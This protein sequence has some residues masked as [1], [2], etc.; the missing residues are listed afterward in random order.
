MDLRLM[1]TSFRFA[2]RQGLPWVRRRTP[3]GS[4]PRPFWH[5]LAADQR[6][7]SMLEF[8]MVGPML[9]LL[10]MVIVDLGIMLTTQSMLDGAARDAA[11]LIRT[12]Q[13]AASSNPLSTFQTL[14]CSDMSP[15]MSTST[16]QSQVLFEVNC[17][18]SGTVSGCLTTNLGFG[19][20][21]FSG[22]T[23]NQGQAGAAGSGT[24]CNFNPGSSTTIVG[25]RVTYN[26]KFIVPWVGRC[27]TGGACWFGMGTSGASGTGGGNAVPLV[28][29]VVFQ[30]EP[31]P[32]S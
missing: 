17:Y 25:V 9:V 23:Y 7:T 6:G 22:C 13:V 15:V 1:L 32:A 19:A 29:T 28:S 18:T 12:G 21:S 14:L 5:R 10:M 20:V 31:F 26:R 3:V 11:R 27:L 16:C 4:P 30:N 2:A 8:A 24:Q